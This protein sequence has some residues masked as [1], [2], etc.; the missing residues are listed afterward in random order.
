VIKQISR[1]VAIC[2]LAAGTSQMAGAT[3]LTSISVNDGHPVWEI[4]RQLQ[5]RYGYAITYEDP[6]YSN[7]EDFE[8]E[9]SQ[10]V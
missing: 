6:R 3:T 9:S 1:K 7:E 4:A 2:V 10:R 5:E 8:D